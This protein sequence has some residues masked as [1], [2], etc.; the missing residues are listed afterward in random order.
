MSMVN[1][2]S[3]CGA[4]R[5]APWKVAFYERGPGKPLTERF[6]T[7]EASHKKDWYLTAVVRQSS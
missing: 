1:S 6:A 5:F 4:L 7:W 2:I 3:S